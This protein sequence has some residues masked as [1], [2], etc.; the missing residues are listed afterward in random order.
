MLLCE[1]RS[2]VSSKIY[3]VVSKYLDGILEESIT[4]LGRI[5]ELLSKAPLFSRQLK[6]KQVILSTSTTTVRI[7]LL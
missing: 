6:I 1:N 7:A 4:H 5:L 2:V 3:N